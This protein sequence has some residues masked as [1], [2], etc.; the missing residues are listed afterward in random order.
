MQGAPR[1]LL[2][3]NVAA[4]GLK[5]ASVFT[6]CDNRIAQRAFE[7]AGFTKAVRYPDSEFGMSWV[8]IAPLIAQ[9]R[10]SGQ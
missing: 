10:I 2:T 5:R 6:A 8:M 3:C 4:P 9:R 1:R 7:K